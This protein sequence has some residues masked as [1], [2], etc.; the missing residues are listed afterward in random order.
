MK[1]YHGYSPYEPREVLGEVH[2][3]TNGCIV[4]KNI[5]FENSI[6]IA[7]FKQA[8][9]ANLLPNQFY[10]AYGADQYYRESNCVVYFNPMHDGETVS[11]DYLQVGTIIIAQ[12]LNEI[13]AHLEND[14][15]HTAIKDIPFASRLEAGLVR[16]GD[17]LGMLGEELYVRLGEGLTLVNNRICVAGAS[18]VS[19]GGALPY[20]LQPATTESLGG[21]IVGDGF[22]VSADGRIDVTLQGGN[23]FTLT[24]A[25]AD[26]LGGIMVGKNLSI[27]NGTLSS[28]FYL[29]TIPSTID[30]AMWLQF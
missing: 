4:L 26:S 19:G 29:D 12:D 11:V 9:T 13:K 8:D 6:D 21:V 16:V 5:P 22:S 3:I 25:T 20:T 2:T 7:G 28:F 17:G 15:I 24:A 27:D 1:F 30:G 10:C 18:S 23:N 14:T